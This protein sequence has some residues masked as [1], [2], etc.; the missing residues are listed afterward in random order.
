MLCAP[1]P[2]HHHRHP[3][4]L[5]SAS[6]P[7]Y[8]SRSNTSGA[9]EDDFYSSQNF[10]TVNHSSSILSASHS[11]EPYSPDSSSEVSSTQQHSNYHYVPRGHLD[12]LTSPSDHDTITMYHQHVHSSSGTQNLLYSDPSRPPEDAEVAHHHQQQPSYPLSLS[13]SRRSPPANILTDNLVASTSDSERDAAPYSAPPTSPPSEALQSQPQHAHP[14]FSFPPPMSAPHSQSMFSRFSH[15]PLGTDPPTVP[16]TGNNSRYQFNNLGLD[17][18]MSEPVLGARASYPQSAAHGHTQAEFSY[19]ATAASSGSTIHVAQPP[20]S[21]RPSSSQ[22]SSYSSYS[23]QQG[24]HRAGSGASDN[25]GTTSGQSWQLGKSDLELEGGEGVGTGIMPGLGGSPV[26]P[27]Y[28]PSVASG[29]DTSVQGLSSPRSPQLLKQQVQTPS[30]A[31]SARNSGGRNSKTYS[32]VSLPG[33]A[34]KKRPRRR[35]DEIERLYQCR[36][37]SCALS[38]ATLNSC[39][40][41]CSSRIQLAE[42]QQSIRHIEPSERSCHY[43]EARLEAE[44]R[45]FVP[46]YT[47]ADIVSEV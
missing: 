18:R 47:S 27:L 35:Y 21:P 5:S 14:S 6:S 46:F 34:V 38:A 10:N 13:H 26:S 29:S 37:V 16:N 41:V 20:L 9:A 22:Y 33:N 36:S 40:A 12:A 3:S 11:P 28:A 44:S 4:F 17:R 31:D 25:Y 8:R 15:N 24:H 7:P 45:R 2:A 1:L 23:N 43:A 19:S 42:L 32:F 39:K 30:R